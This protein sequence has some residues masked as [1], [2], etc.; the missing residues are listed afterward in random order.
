MGADPTVAR[1]GAGVDVV[2]ELAASGFTGAVEAG[3]GGFGAVYRCTQTG[4]DRPVAVKVLT[5]GLAD[6]RA[7]FVREQQAMGRLTGHPNIVAV[8]DI[9]ELQGGSP[10]LV[11]PFCGRGSVQERIA[12]LGRLQLDE[13]LRLGVK[14]AGA[15][16]SAHRLG[17]LHRD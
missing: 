9:G 11:M 2:A 16:A 3:R 12:R 7:R 10:Y 1:H 6:D 13:T 14:M 8:L 17:I 4:L 5:D 15:L